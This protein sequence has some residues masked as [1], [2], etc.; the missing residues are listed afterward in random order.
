MDLS[1]AERTKLREKISQERSKQ[2]IIIRDIEQQLS[3]LK[4]SRRPMS[5]SEARLSELRAI[6]KLALREKA[7]QTADRLD[8]LIMGYQRGSANRERQPREGQ[9]RQRR[10]RPVREEKTR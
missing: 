7:A 6:H 8:K 1:E 3:A 9:P 2:Q 4:G 10:E 5:M